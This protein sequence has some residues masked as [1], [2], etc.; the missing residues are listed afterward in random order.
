[1]QRSIGISY[2]PDS[3]LKDTTL[4]GRR[5]DYLGYVVRLAARWPIGS[6]GM[7][8]RTGLELGY[9]PETHVFDAATS[10]EEAD[11]LAWNVV[12]SL[13]DFIPGHNIGINYGQ[14]GAG[15][16]L[17]PNFRNNEESIELRYVWRPKNFPTIDARV[18][19]REDI[20][21]EPGSLRKRE[22]FDVFLRLT[23]Q[24]DL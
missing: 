19:R 13:M 14:T 22:I 6:A 16:L 17:S 23:W 5:E 11:G 3:L 15:W 7:R 20:D 18:R 12:A 10:D 24:F 8:L 9:A 2:L 1:V 21:L 4:D